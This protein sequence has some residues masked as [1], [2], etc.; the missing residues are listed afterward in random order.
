MVLLIRLVRTKLSLCF[1]FAVVCVEK[2]WSIAFFTWMQNWTT[3]LDDKALCQWRLPA[4]C[5]FSC[6]LN[7]PC[8]KP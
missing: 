7:H 6:I 3:A 4:D 8:D 1:I 5:Q 2:S